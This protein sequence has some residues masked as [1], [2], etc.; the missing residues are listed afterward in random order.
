[1]FMVALDITP[2]AE[3]DVQA[4]LTQRGRFQTLNSNLPH[5]TFLGQRENGLPA[6]GLRSLTTGGQKFWITSTGK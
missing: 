3:K 2:F 5:F 4:I 1:M 6:P